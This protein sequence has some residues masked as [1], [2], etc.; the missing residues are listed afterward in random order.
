MDSIRNTAEARTA[1]ANQLLATIDESRAREAAMSDARVE[2]TQRVMD[3]RNAALQTTTQ[4]VLSAAGAI[5]AL[6]SG[7]GKIAG[8]V[9]S[10]L[11]PAA[12]VPS[13]PFVNP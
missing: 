12:V 11:G 2:R 10:A 1:S 4:G 8:P 3:E 6:I 5:A 9:T 13:N 7:L